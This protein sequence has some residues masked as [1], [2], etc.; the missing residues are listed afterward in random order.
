MNDFK[1]YFS[2]FQI[3]KYKD[4]Y[5]FE[6]ITVDDEDALQ[7]YQIITMTITE[8]GEQTISLSQKDNRF[9]PEENDIEYSQCRLVVARVTDQGLEFVK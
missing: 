1:Y 4:G 6:N 9:Y 2:R 3:C 7:E 8:T 5:N